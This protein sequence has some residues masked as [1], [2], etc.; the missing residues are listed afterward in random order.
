MLEILI[1]LLN[2]SKMFFLLF[3]TIK[4]FVTAQ[5]LR[6]EA[7]VHLAS[8]ATRPLSPLYRRCLAIEWNSFH[9]P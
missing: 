8:R 6:G 2:F 1:L 5:N 4:I 7:V 3:L 9:T